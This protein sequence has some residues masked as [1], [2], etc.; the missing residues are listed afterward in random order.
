MRE[1]EGRH[2]T[3]AVDAGAADLPGTVKAVM[4]GVSRVM[5][6]VAYRL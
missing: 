1:D 3:T 6:A 5:T 4:T 2:A